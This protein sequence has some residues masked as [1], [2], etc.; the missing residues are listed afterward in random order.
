MVVA[1]LEDNVTGFGCAGGLEFVFH[2]ER[3]SSGFD[4]VLCEYPRYVAGAVP[5][6]IVFTTPN[7]GAAD[8]GFCGFNNS[9]LGFVGADGCG[10]FGVDATGR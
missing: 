4:A 5:G 6:F 7:I 10:G 2:G 8:T 9:G 1:A 3:V